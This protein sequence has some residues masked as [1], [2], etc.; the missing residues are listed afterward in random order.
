[1]SAPPSA[2]I[3]LVDDNQ[4]N[5]YVISRI[6]QRAGFA[7]EECVTGQEGLQ[8]VLTLPDLVILDVKLPDISGTEVCRRIK[9]D[10]ITGLIPVLQ[11]SASFTSSESKVAA[12]EGGADGY[13]THPIEPPVLL[14]T[15]RSL[16]RLKQAETVSRQSAEE[17]KSTFDALSECLVLLDVENRVMR[18]N[19]AFA[20]LTGVGNEVIGQD[21][22]EILGKVLGSA[23]FL[24]QNRSGRYSGE[25]RHDSLW[26][27]VTVDSVTSGG[28]RI[29]SIVV[30]T[31]ITARKLAAQSLHNAE[32]LA[33]T[34]RL[35]QTI[36]HEINN[37]LEA[38]TN[39]IFLAQYSATEPEVL[40]F[41][42]QA[43]AELERVAKI[44]KQ[45]LS[46]HR[47]TKT[48]VQVEAHE[49]LDNVGSLYRPQVLARQIQFEWNT[50]PELPT[51]CGYPGELRQALANL[52]G[53]ALDASRQGGR[54]VMRARSAWNGT[55]HGVAFTVHDEGAGIPAEIRDR[56]LDPFF[57]TKELKGT[58]LGLWLTKNIVTKHGGS[59]RF[60]SRQTPGHSGSSF[61]LF[62][63]VTEA[64]CLETIVS[65][66]QA[67]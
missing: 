66:K 7:V 63:P 23:D 24:K 65:S 11:I 58:G 10:V 51:I 26:F 56:I 61:R 62:L 39:L 36:A 22:S 27:A 53:N 16:L 3:L 43:M 42:R 52:L 29:G 48:A 35:A 34:G 4:Q 5:R 59:L 13:L 30:L 20:E 40:E 60:R 37:P 54:I 21:G 47:D 38:L 18:F 50:S 14:A 41:L 17:W 49:L 6:L 67:S 31:D 12:L 8:R 25:L 9:S 44:T 55:Q 64:A 46:F 15:V 33:A 1:M 19:K 57:T 45:I 2:R 28:Q 32:R